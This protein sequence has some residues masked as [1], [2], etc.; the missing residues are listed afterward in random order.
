MTST[1]ERNSVSTT[2]Y[3]ATFG[4]VI[5]GLN[6]ASPT[7]ETIATLSELLLEHGVLFF[8]ECPLTDE[9]HLNLANCLGIPSVFPLSRIVAKPGAKIPNLSEIIDTA[10]NPP[11]ADDWHTDITWIAE[12]P[13]IAILQG[14]D[15]P[16]RGGDTLWGDLY[17][18]YDS[19]SP[20]MQSICEQISV[21]HRVSDVI[22]QKAQERG[23]AEAPKLLLEHF[24]P[25]V[26]PLVRTHP[27]TGRKALFVAGGFMHA[28]QGMTDEESRW[29]IDWLNA[30]VSN[31]NFHLR[32][33]WSPGD[34]A[35]WDERR[36]IHRALA[37]HFPSYRRMRRCTLDGDK[38]F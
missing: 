31:P 23:G 19:L 27:E 28:I 8:P 7:D 33:R 4:A 32:W 22:L 14:I 20:P 26:H 36:T 3:G 21:V 9:E 10:D 29:W 2:P 17:F 16:E 12:P 13:K 25:V 6:L 15:I 30:Y 34:L 37:N 11:D 5:R 18:A 38:P 24:P 1:T 35:I